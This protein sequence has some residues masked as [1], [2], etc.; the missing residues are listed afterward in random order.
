LRR[1]FLLFGSTLLIIGLILFIGVASIT[2]YPQKFGPVLD[3]SYEHKL[4]PWVG[5]MQ[6]MTQFIS[7]VGIFSIILMTIGSVICIYGV[8]AKSKLFTSK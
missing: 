2:F 6:Q 5:T 8:V 4:E 7:F 3:V 1:M